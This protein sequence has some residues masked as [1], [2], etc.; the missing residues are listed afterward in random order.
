MTNNGSALK[1][2]IRRK[3]PLQFTVRTLI[4]LTFLAALVGYLLQPGHLLSGKINVELKI[5]GFRYETEAGSGRKC[6]VAVVKVTNKSGIRLW[7]QGSFR[8]NPDSIVFYPSD[9]TANATLDFLA[10]SCSPERLAFDARETFTFFASVPEQARSVRVGV[11]FASRWFG[12]IDSLATSSDVMVPSDV[13]KKP[14]KPGG[15][16]PEKPGGG[17]TLDVSAGTGATNSR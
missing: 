5:E 3:W 8:G 15:E 7:Y 14:E 9:S 4:S 1:L 13:T 16:K 6:F 11:A 2:P 10:E 17:P 12:P